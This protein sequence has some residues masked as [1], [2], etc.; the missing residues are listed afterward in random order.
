MHAT[1][2]SKVLASYRVYSFNVKYRIGK[3]VMVAKLN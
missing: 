2:V 1:V 3:M